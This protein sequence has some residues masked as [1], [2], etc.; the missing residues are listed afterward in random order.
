MLLYLDQMASHC[1]VFCTC[2]NQEPDAQGWFR[3]MRH[4]GAECVVCSECEQKLWAEHSLNDEGYVANYLPTAGGVYSGAKK[5]KLSET[6]QTTL[7]DEKCKHFTNFVVYAYEKLTAAR[8]S[9]TYGP[10]RIAPKVP[11]SRPY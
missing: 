11:Q 4:Y 2:S 8:A 7:L 10:T 6:S 3:R 1:C 5:Q 9:S